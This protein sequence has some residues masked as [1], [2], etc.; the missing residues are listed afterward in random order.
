MKYFIFLILL[1]SSL[2]T[3]S[4]KKGSFK[5]DK[6]EIGYIAIV[7]PDSASSISSFAAAELK[8]HLDLIFKGD[9]KITSLSTGNKYKK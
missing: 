1:L 4:C 8:K 7:I 2:V 9:I 3:V 5:I 6:S